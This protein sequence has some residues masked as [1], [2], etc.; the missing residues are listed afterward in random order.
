[1]DAKREP[2][3]EFKGV[4]KTFGNR[5]ILNRIDLSVYEGEVT[6]L[7]GLSGTGKSV[8]LKHIIG[9][10]KPDEGQILYRGKPID[11]MSKK[12]WND[13]IGQISYMFQNNALFDSMTVFE[14]VAMPLKYT[15]KLKKK[16]I[17]VKAMARIEQT[18]LT[19]VADKYPSE[20]SGGMQ[21]RAAL[22]RALVSDPNI[23]LFD[24]PTTGQDP[25]RKNAILSMVAEYQKRFGFTA[26][27]IS[28][29]IPDVY[30]ISNRILALYDR[31]IVFQGDPEDFEAL[32]H[33]FRQELISS[34]ESLGQELTGLYSKRHFKVRYQSDLSQRHPDASYAA[35]VFTIDDLDAITKNMSHDVAQ[36][37][38]RSLGAYINKHFGAV[39]GFSSRQTINEYATVL[40]YSNLEESERIM[41]DFS[42][43]FKEHG[44]KGYEEHEIWELDPN[45]ENEEPSGEYVDFSVLAGLAQGKPQIEIE[46]VMEFARFNQKELARFR[47][48]RGGKAQ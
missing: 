27:L 9:M 34:L 46:S 3:I 17:E 48:A 42:K 25:I 29:E 37:I 15:T 24:E 4:S 22:A 20:I 43:D 1:M 5:N 35:A 36:Q 39:G 11:Q 47:C 10:L 23:V 7:I 2:L 26:L 21:K 16:E 6:T 30:F 40:P 13:Y 8:T 12:E 41:E 44:I 18:E 31:K 38:I 45:I 32:D 19:E 28:H 33:P 14:N